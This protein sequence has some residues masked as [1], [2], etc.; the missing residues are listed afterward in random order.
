MSRFRIRDVCSAVCRLSRRPGE[1]SWPR[2]TLYPMSNYVGAPSVTS[3]AYSDAPL[4]RFGLAWIN[5]WDRTKVV[6]M[7]DGPVSMDDVVLRKKSVSSFQ[8]PGLAPYCTYAEQLYRPSGLSILVNS[9][10][11]LGD[12]QIKSCE[13]QLG[14]RG[15]AKTVQVPQLMQKPM[16]LKLYM[17]SPGVIGEPY[18]PPPPPLPFLRRWFTKEGWARKKQSFMGM[19]KTSYTIAKLR[20][21]TKGYSQQKFYQE[22]SDLYKQINVALAEGERTTL[23]HLVTD[24]VFSI[25]KNELKH[26]EG[27]TWAKVDWEMVGPIS[28]M[29]TVQGRLIGVDK[30]NHDNAFVQLTVRIT[31]KQKFAAYDKRGKLVAGDPDKELLV[32]D[33][34]VF[35]KPLLLSEAKWRLCAR[36]SV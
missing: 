4:H 15:F 34:W 21:K 13:K 28:K 25:M 12:K 7:V 23:R 29:R 27:S 36:L 1:E 30:N 5:E 26:R 33:I 31:S 6:G 8:Q 22:A 9:S 24:S 20:Q 32:E 18:K 19:V 35:E 17:G 11:A 10:S 3:R 16:K 2:R 14:V